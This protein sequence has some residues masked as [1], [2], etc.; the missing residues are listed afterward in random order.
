MSLG[1]LVRELEGKLVNEL[2]DRFSHSHAVRLGIFLTQILSVNQSN[3][4]QVLV[5]GVLDSVLV[6]CVSWRTCEV[7]IRNSKYI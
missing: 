6:P 2:P 4:L 7:N 5:P 1:S 3:S